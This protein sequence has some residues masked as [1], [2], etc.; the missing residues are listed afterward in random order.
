[1]GML[2]RLLGK[3]KLP[4]PQPPATVAP[5]FGEIRDN[6]VTAVLC[7][8]R[9]DLE[10]VGES[11]HQEELWQLVGGHTSQHVRVESVAI[12]LPERDNPHDPNAVTVWIAG[13][14]VGH[15]SRE[16]AQQ[17]R[18]GLLA[19]MTKHN[20]PVA[21]NGVITG[22]GP[23]PGGIG[24]LGV[25][26]H[27]DPTD[28]GLAATPHP[29]GPHV[30][31]GQSETHPGQLAWLATLPPNDAAA[32]KTLRGLLGE[33]TDPVERHFLYAQLESRLYRCRD[34]FDSAL[35]EYDAACQAHDDEMASIR[36]ALI[37]EFE[38]LPLLE[39]YRQA[40]IR[41]EKA[42]DFTHATWWATRGLEVYGDD[43]LR[44]EDVEDLERRVQ[45]C[46]RRLH[47]PEKPSAGPRPRRA[48]SAAVVTGAPPVVE[49]LH[50]EACGEPF[51]RAKVP[52]RKPK[53]CP[54]CRERYGSPTGRSS[55]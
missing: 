32:I 17:M 55:T 19:L 50:C 36:P 28:F 12:L 49:T 31:T 52:G 6:Q 23:R 26:L 3:G 1:M 35:G 34:V 22:G 5:E 47:P 25:W 2:G 4:T 53:R 37:A 48:T 18:P 16:S 30:R 7:D 29:E 9:D 33:R 43:A 51:E 8:G 20:K 45:R 40:A 15:L 13:L 11:F 10:V 42:H 41:H 39:L 46:D 21:L 14:Q 44:S 27:F 54:G 24:F 38:G